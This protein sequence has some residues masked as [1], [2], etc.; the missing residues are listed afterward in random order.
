VWPAWVLGAI[1]AISGGICL[2][3]NIDPSWAVIG[4]SFAAIPV[5]IWVALRQPVPT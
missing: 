3:L 4:T 5:V 2:A 1:A